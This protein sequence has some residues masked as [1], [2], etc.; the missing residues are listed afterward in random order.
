MDIGLGLNQET[1]GLRVPA[2]DGP[3]Q[4]GVSGVSFRVDVRTVRKQRLDDLQIARACGRHERRQ[5]A[6]LSDVRIGSRS[7]QPLHHQDAGV[8]DGPGERRHAVVF[9]GVGVRACLQQQVH[10]FEVVSMGGIEERRRS[11]GP[12]RVRVYPL[13]EQRPE[14]DLVLL[15]SS[16]DQPL[17]GTRGRRH[18]RL[19]H[20]RRNQPRGPGPGDA[21][22]HGCAS[23][24]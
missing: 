2:C 19:C 14:G 8:F 13:F 20:T 11:V 17:I 23:C 16:G 6:R 24:S 10:G 21:E 12:R 4:G 3:H 5:T 9:R 7:Q 22:D 15:G 18:A 1:R